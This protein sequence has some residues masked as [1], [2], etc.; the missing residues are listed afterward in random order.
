MKLTPQ[1]YHFSFSSS[2]KLDFKP[3]QYLEWTVPHKRP[4]LRG[5]RRYF[6]IASSPTEKDIQ[7]GVRFE[8]KGSSFKKALLDLDD[9]RKI[10]ASQLTGDFT[11]PND[12][13]KKLV[14][15]AG[16]IGVT[17]FRSIA[18]YLIDKNEKR[19][20][21]LFFACS[22]PTEFIYQEIFDKAKNIGLRTNYVI[23]KK[24]NAPKN[25]Q[26]I[27]GY[28]SP[29]TVREKLPDYKERDYYLS[30]PISM[31]EAYKSLL[32]KLGIPKHRIHTDYFPGF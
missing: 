22:S 4:D 25:W 16:G 10:V 18:K 1:I 15:I 17:P 6:T 13:K 20:I 11:L 26:G 27:V 31:V 12:K 7:L 30:G 8:Q 23:T 5:N 28:L 14:F 2:Q 19:D 9:Q 21:V 29:E 24:E 32:S 3:G